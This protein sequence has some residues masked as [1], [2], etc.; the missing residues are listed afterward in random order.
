MLARSEHIGVINGQPVRFNQPLGHHTGQLRHGGLHAR[1]PLARN[2]Q[3]RQIRV[4][5]IAVIGRIFFGAHGTGFASV[6]V[7]QNS[8]LLN[9]IAVFNLLNLPQDLKVNGL[10]H[11]AKAVQVFDLTPGTQLSAW[12]A[13]RDVGVA[14]KAPLLHVAVANTNPRYQFVKLF[15]IG[16]SLGAGPHIGLSHNFKQRRAGAV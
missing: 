15:G 7:K 11:E 4:G 12:L 16:N 2:D 14:P 6:W 13:H 9:R 5:E 10:L 3:W 1:D 8:C